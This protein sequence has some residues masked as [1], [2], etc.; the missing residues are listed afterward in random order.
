MPLEEERVPPSMKDT[1]VMLWK[2][3]EDFAPRKRHLSYDTSMLS[4]QPSEK[5]TA[6]HSKDQREAVKSI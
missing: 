3:L 5:G 1:V 4:M 2:K 6:L